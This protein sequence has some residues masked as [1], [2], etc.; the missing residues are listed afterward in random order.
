[1]VCSLT[2]R[3]W[4]FGRTYC[5]HF[6]SKIIHSKDQ[7]VCS[8]DRRNISSW[9]LVSIYR[10][11]G[12]MLPNTITTIRNFKTFLDHVHQHLGAQERP[13]SYMFDILKAVNVHIISFWHMTSCRLVDIQKMV[14]PSEFLLVYLAIK[15]HSVLSQMVVLKNLLLI[16]QK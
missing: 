12:V 6:Q 3:H 2:G 8:E 4:H 16:F 10:V 15:I 11:H 1:M 7:M 13:V 9:T 14:S 5:L